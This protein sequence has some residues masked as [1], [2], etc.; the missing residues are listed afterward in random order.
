MGEFLGDSGNRR[1]YTHVETMGDKLHM[2]RSV[3]A[4]FIAHQILQSTDGCGQSGDKTRR[5]AIQAQFERLTLG[6]A[7]YERHQIAWLV[8][9]RLSAPIL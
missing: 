8:N 4:N 7:E 1:E 6:L 9:F 5:E 3:D 2:S